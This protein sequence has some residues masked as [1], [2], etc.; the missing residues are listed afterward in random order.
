MFNAINMFWIL[1]ACYGLFFFES[2]IAWKKQIISLNAKTGLSL[3]I[4]GI[5]K[6]NIV[7]II[8]LGLPLILFYNNWHDLIAWP[9]FNSLLRVLL[10]LSLLMIIVGI[11]LQ[12]TIKESKPSFKHKK[13]NQ[14][15]LRSPEIFYLTIRFIFLVIYE[16]FFRG[17]LLFI[18]TIA[19]GTTAA[20]AINIFLYAG[21]HSFNGRN[22]MLAC[23]PFGLVVC[24]IT[25]WYQSILPAIALHLA[26]ALVNEIYLLCF[27]IPKSKTV[28]L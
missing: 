20:I 22:E 27:Y 1:I 6:K 7:G 17:L 4:T 18:S 2:L 13:R 9:V 26:L 3:S 10:I 19:F 12:H 25:I 23:V 16:C 15:V 14:F 8:I 28:R 11:S 24:G 21:I 5:S